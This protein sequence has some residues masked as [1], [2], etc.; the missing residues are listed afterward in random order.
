[1]S[2]QY[3][4]NQPYSTSR[5]QTPPQAPNGGSN[6]YD[7]TPNYQGYQ[8]RPNPGAPNYQNYQQPPYGQHPYYT[9]V[10]ESLRLAAFII[11]LIATIIIAFP[12]FGIALAWGI[13]MTVMTYRII[14]SP[15]KH[16]GLGVCSIIFLGFIAGILILCSG[17]RDKEAY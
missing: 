16:I 9:P 6:Q 4:N 3:G 12:T 10:N 2:N 14:K 7:A 13:P 15:Y 1:M 8:Q 17:G 11:N 5:Q